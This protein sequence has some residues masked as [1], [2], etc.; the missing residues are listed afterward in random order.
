VST[1]PSLVRLFVV[2]ATSIVMLISLSSAGN[3]SSCSNVVGSAFY[4]SLDEFHPTYLYVAG[5]LERGVRTLIYVGEYDWICNWVG[6]SRWVER[7]EWSGGEE[8]RATSE[9]TWKF[10]GEDAGRKRTAGN[11]SFVTIRGAGHMVGAL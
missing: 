6:N 1:M 9:G 3:F 4:A 8:Y 2:H 11:L 10:E 5:L 7:L